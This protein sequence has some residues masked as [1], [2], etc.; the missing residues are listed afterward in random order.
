VIAGRGGMGVVWQAHDELL[1]RDV[2]VKELRWPAGLSAA[3]RQA[4]CRGVV[5]EA[6]LA[7]RVRHPHVIQVFDVAEEDGCPWI[8]MEFVCGRSLREEIE[9]RGTLRPAEA[10]RVG[11]GILAA[12]RAVHDAGI[13]HRDVKPANILLARDRVV[14]TDFGI[15]RAAGAAE[16]ASV[17]EALVGSPSYLPPERAWGEESGAPGDLWG[18]GAALYAAVEGHGPF[19]RNG[20]LASMTAVLTDEPR[21]A[22]HAGELWPVI[23]GLLRKDPAERLDTAAAMR[24]LRRVAAA[25]AVPAPRPAARLAAALASPLAHARLVDRRRQMTVGS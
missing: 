1:G 16:P 6:R 18:L 10:V 8:V 20:A 13:T 9:A 17:A 22:A 12:L 15:A 23:S 21:P 25:G 5:R 2:A 11:L 3:L 14:L 24:L 7:A 19:D 4:A